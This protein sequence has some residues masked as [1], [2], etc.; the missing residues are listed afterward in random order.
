MSS[1]SPQVNSEAPSHS[2]QTPVAALN[3]P[4]LAAG[5]AGETGGTGVAG[6]AA[7]SGLAAAS[8]TVTGLPKAGPGAAATA[9]GDE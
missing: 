9:G 1:G 3:P 7:T 8:N 5:R 6:D 2:V 4:L